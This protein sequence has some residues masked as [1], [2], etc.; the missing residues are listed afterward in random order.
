MRQLSITIIIVAVFGF[1]TTVIALRTQK[2]AIK[3]CNYCPPGFELSEDNQCLS[4]SLYQQYASLRNSGVG[5]LKTA[6]PASRNGFSPQQ[7][8]LGRYLFFDPVL[9]KDGSIACS[10]CHDPDYGFSDGRPVSIGI[11]GTPLKRSA[12]SLWN[13]A[14]LNSF[15]GMVVHQVWK[16]KC[17]D[18][19]IQVKKWV[20]PKLIS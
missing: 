2:P 12:P 4:R 8:D 16:S 6:L 17:R 9:S 3:L 10:S 14:Y 18:L 11:K 20:V 1:F 15:F 13:V 19:F 5:G 7:I